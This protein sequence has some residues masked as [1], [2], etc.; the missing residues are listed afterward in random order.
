[1]YVRFRWSAE[2]DE[3]TREMERFL[4]HLARR[5]GSTIVFQPSTW[6]PRLDLYETADCL[7]AVAELPGMAPEQIEVIA[8]RDTL[9]IRGVREETALPGCARGDQKKAYHLMEIPLGIFERTVPLPSP[10]DVERATAE[11]QAG[12]LEI[13]LPKAVAIPAGRVTIRPRTQEPSPD[14]NSSQAGVKVHG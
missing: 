10:V 8:D 14:M 7:V 9:T 6:Q 3:L 11:Y 5:K 13:R 1:V 2:F 12:F 4:D